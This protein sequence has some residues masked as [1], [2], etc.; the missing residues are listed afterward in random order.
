VDPGSDPQQFVTRLFNWIDRPWLPSTTGTRTATSIEV[1]GLTPAIVDTFFA[2]AVGQ[3]ITPSLAVFNAS[4]PEGNGPGLVVPVAATVSSVPAATNP[5][6]EGELAA[7]FRTSRM[8]IAP[9]NAVLPPRTQSAGSLAFRV[10][11]SQV[12][13]VPISVDYQTVDGTAT[14]A[15]GDYTPTSG[16]LNFAPGDSALDI[17]VPFGA[18]STPEHNETFG[19]ML[20]NAT[21]ATIDTPTATGTIIDDDDLIAPTAQVIYPNG[22]EVI[23]QNQQVTLQWTASDNVGVNGVDIQ[24]VNGASVTT[25]ASNYPNTG[26]YN[27]LSTGPPSTKM[28]F[29]VVAHDDNHATTDNSD[30]NWEISIYTIG[31]ADELPVAFALAAPSP[32]P[33]TAGPNR[34]AFSVPR[35][36]QVRLTV[37]DVRGRMMAKLA[38]G[39]LP[40]G[41]HMRTWDATSVP[42]GVYFVRFEAPGFRADRRLVVL[43]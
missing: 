8:P 43:P 9:L 24:L 30:A 35:D 21:G 33:A 32:N 39:L 13:V 27:W 14:V 7:P 36:A 29:R 25:L 31:V 20:S 22:G 28:K 11:L 3:P 37:H 2:M 41:H 34:I 1:L 18:D 26:S 12:A 38:D 5:L 10:R 19:I 16:T 17:V 15:D 40:A 6:Y 4:S 42:A 23:H